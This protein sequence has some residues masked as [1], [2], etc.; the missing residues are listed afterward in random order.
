M[1]PFNLDLALTGVPVVLRGGQ[2]AFVRHYET[3]YVTDFPLSGI[4]IRKDGTAD[5]L[6]WTLRG[7]HNLAGGPFDLDIVGMWE[8]TIMIG[9]MEVPEPAREPLGY[10][11]RYY[12][13]G[14]VHGNSPFVWEG[15]EYD[16]CWLRE[17]RI[18]L[19]KD[20]WRKHHEALI[21]I[22]G[23]TP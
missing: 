4:F 16:K 9:D 21:K 18:Q 8:P 23:G 19:T 10:N 20:G 2:K 11:Q 7:R 15:D 17:G 6:S 5:N 3:N 22:S 12:V 14:F 1:K 13:V